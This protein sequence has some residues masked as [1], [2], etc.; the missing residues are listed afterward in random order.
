MFKP[1]WMTLEHQA[2]QL[3]EDNNNHVERIKTLEQEI[4][5][6]ETRMYELD[7]QLSDF[8]DKLDALRKAFA[9]IDLGI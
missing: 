3:Q 7:K 5:E 8:E 4:A 6:W 2:N 9:A 1:D